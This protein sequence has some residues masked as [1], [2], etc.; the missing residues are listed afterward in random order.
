M[1]AL[2][3]RSFLP[4]EGFI[5][6]G[7]EIVQGGVRVDLG[8]GESPVAKKELD[9]PGVGILEHHGCIGVPEKMGVDLL[10]KERLAETLD[11]G[12]DRP[13]SKMT[14]AACCRKKVGAGVTGKLGRKADK[15]VGEDEF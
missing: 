15:E 2:F 14:C 1:R 11:I 8:R 4:G 9:L 3:F 13:G 10:F 7:G 5:N 6:G 12:L